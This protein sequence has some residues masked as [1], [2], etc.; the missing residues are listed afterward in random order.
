[1]LAWACRLNAPA[2]VTLCL[3]PLCSL[4]LQHLPGLYAVAMVAASLLLGGAVRVIPFT[5]FGTYLSWAYLRFVQS[6]NGAR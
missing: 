2:P 1:V 3:L 4:L 6:R 5:L